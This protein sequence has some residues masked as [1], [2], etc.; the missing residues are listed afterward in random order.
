LGAGS[1]ALKTAAA[2]SGGT[3]RAADRI[4]YEEGVAVHRESHG[5]VQPRN[6]AGRWG[7]WLKLHLAGHV[8]LQYLIGVRGGERDRLAINVYSFSLVPAKPTD[9]RNEE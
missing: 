2:G 1:L 8:S 6:K 4:R 9:R 3:N 7:L 5:S